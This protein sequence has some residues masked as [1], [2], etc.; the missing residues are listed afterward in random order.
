[1]NR[2]RLG[3]IGAGSVVREIYRHLYF[4]SDYSH[5]L[6]IEAVADPNDKALNDFADQYHIP[7]H[8][9]FADYHEMIRQVQLDA[10][11]V[12][13]PDQLH[14]EPTIFALGNDLDVMVAK[15]LASSIADAHAIIE[16]ARRTGRLVTVDFHKREDPRIKEVTTRYH[17]GAY[18][19]FQLAVLYMLDKLCVADPNY[20]PQYF[21]SPDFCEKNTPITFLTVHMAD[22]LVQMVSLKPISVRATAY[23]QKLPSLRPVPS[24]GYDMCDVEVLLENGGVAHIVTCWHLPNSAH[25]MTVQ[26]SRLIC[27]DAMIDLAIDM[28]G[29]RE[30]T[31]NGIQERNPLFRNFEP[32][33][34]V[35][36]YGIS[37]PGNLYRKIL[38]SRNNQ[39]PRDEHAEIIG[40]FATG[41]YATVICEAAGVSIENGHT[42]DGVTR[43]TEIDVAELLHRRIGNAADRYL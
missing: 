27:T 17:S 35:S 25:A 34:S 20:R 32:D 40:P 24:K 10:V 3:V 13:T 5:L 42:I 38:R 7:A 6:S 31:E 21:A 29:C 28:P 19:R 14:R 23:S 36:G 41:F 2:L 30:I 11:Q 1:M 22:A 9:R 4:H 12:N 18:G 37:H 26:S 43:G 33:G 8:R 39:M 15:P 16:A